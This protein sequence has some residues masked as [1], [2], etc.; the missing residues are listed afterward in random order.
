MYEDTPDF[1]N[2]INPR[3]WINVGDAD[4]PDDK[5]IL[6]QEGGIYDSENDICRP[7]KPFPSWVPDGNSWISPVPPPNNNA[8]GYLWNE[9]EQS[10]LQD[11]AFGL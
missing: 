11:P 5:Y 1:L 9:A 10:W 4:V 3:V 7:P 8:T 2:K 6:A